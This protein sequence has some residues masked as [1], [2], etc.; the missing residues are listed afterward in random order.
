MKPKRPILVSFSGLDGSGKT[1]QI[2]NLRSVLAARGYS[3]QLLAF[4]DN[5]VVLTRYREGFVHKVYGSEH[6][7]GAPGKP[8]ERRDK[9][10]QRWYLSLARHALYFLDALHLCWVIARARRRAGADVII[11][12]RYAYDE[13]ANLSLRNP[14][15][16]IYIRAVSL[17]IPR[18]DVAYLL[19][20]DPVAARARKPEYPVE[21][22]KKCR[23]AYKQLAMML[24]TMTL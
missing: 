18:P 19:D 7:V 10:I 4:W 23:V 12:D 5:V 15:T 1:T 11:M 16:R 24:G 2:E 3:T 6:G 8:V 13:W 17:L 21:F 14:L 9:N 22:M 20:A